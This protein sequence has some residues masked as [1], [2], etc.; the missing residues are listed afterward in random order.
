MTPHQARVD[1]ASRRRRLPPWL[2]AAALASVGVVGFAAPASASH[3]N[4]GA[5]PA[6]KLA[7]VADLP[8]SDTTYQAFAADDAGR[9]FVSV[10]TS[11]PLLGPP[12]GPSPTT[13]RLWSLGASSPLA[14]LE[15]PSYFSGNP[16]VV[17][18]DQA[19]HMLYLVAYPLLASAS[20]NVMPVPHLV[21]VRLTDTNGAPALSLASDNVLAVLPQGSRVLGLSLHPGD[22][23]GYVIGQ[24]PRP[25]AGIGLYGV[26]VGEFLLPTTTGGVVGPSLVMAVPQCQRVLAERQQAALARVEDPRAGRMLFFAC[27]PAYP[28]VDFSLPTPASIVALGLDDPSATRSF[29]L[30]GFDV[31]AESFFDPN[32]GEAGRLLVGSSGQSRPGLA[33]W[34]FDVRRRMVVGQI[35]ASLLHGVGFDPGTGR[36]FLAVENGVLIASDRGEPLPQALPAVTG[37]PTE[38]GRLGVLPYARAVIMPVAAPE[39]HRFAIYRDLTTSDDL[40]EATFP[41]AAP[42]DRQVSTSTDPNF[43]GSAQAFGLRSTQIGGANALV[44][45]RLGGNG[46]TGSW[47]YTAPQNL[48]TPSMYQ[49]LGVNDGD[50]DLYFGRVNAAHLSQDEASATAVSGEPDALSSGDYQTGGQRLGRS[51]SQASWPLTPA[52]CTVFGA[53][54]ATGTG[55]NGDWGATSPRP[56]VTCDKDGNRV[57]ANAEF[58]GVTA[59]PVTVGSSSSATAIT[60]TADGALDV[61]V[62][63]EARNVVIAGTVHIA[64]VGSRARAQAFG[65]HVGLDGTSTRGRAR[66]EYAA[67][68]EGVSA[69]GFACAQ[70]CDPAAVLARISEALGSQVQVESPAAELVATPGGAHA[71]AW[72]EPWGHLQDTLVNKQLATEIQVPALRLTFVADQDV[73]SRVVVEL[74]G[75][76]ADASAPL[77]K[78]VPTGAAPPTGNGPVAPAVTNPQPPALPT[79]LPPVSPPPAALLAGFNAEPSVAGARQASF[80]DAATGLPAT[81]GLGS[82]VPRVLDTIRQGWRWIIGHA[83]GLSASMWLLFLTPVFL[84]LRRRHLVR[85]ARTDPGA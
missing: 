48:G 81:A 25:T 36:I 56:T 38:D 4:R 63:A 68:F 82:A 28:D 85:L 31:H 7:W 78:D 69:P 46:G 52:R 70:Q 15:L 42:R 74:A 59:G 72:R 54:Q 61:E 27:G 84:A 71:H 19:T 23:K 8:G 3:D 14:T 1:P 12:V 47:W 35:A 20:E 57:V 67:S 75:T 26:S 18:V 53:G 62:T 22:A 37:I 49:M 58:G 80:V 50:R 66:A 13:L 2:A 11:T 41:D 6:P 65:G 39:G 43:S 40:P 32:A 55:T 10:S 44:T 21:A 51:A 33:V 5:T 83:A 29:F 73:P 76:E 16:V 9:R 79:P 60:R 17:S 34:V 24:L 77:V 64:R 30:P 45:N